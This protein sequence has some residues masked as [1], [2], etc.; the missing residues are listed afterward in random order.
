MARRSRVAGR[1]RVRSRERPDTVA[2]MGPATKLARRAVERWNAQDLD[3]VYADWDPGIVVRPDRNFPDSGEIVGK[4]AAKRFW[5]D[6][7]EFMGVGSVEILEEHDLGDRCLMRIRQHVD[8]PASG[9]RG[10]YEWSYLVTEQAGKVV[11]VEFFI[12]R[13]EGLAA[14]GIGEG[15]D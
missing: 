13:N 7:R 11:A 1:H 4:Q 5:E 10:A 14:A 15:A 6:Q 3:A 12:D 9:V 8:A 2:A